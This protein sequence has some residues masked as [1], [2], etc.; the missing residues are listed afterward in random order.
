VTAFA[1]L[2][3]MQKKTVLTLF[4]IVVVGLLFRLIAY[5]FIKI[6]WIIFDEFIY[7]DTARQIVRGEFISQLLRD[8]QRYPFG[9]PLIIASFFG[10]IK[11]PYLQYRLI[12]LFVM[13]LSSVVPVLA[14]KL[15]KNKWVS[16]LTAFY[17]P[18]FVYS[19]SIM[20]ETFY[21]FLLLLLMIILK[22]VVKKDLK[23][24]Y[25]IILSGAVVGLLLYFSRQ[26]RSFGIV[27]LPSMIG[28]AAIAFLV[29]LRARK[30]DNRNLTKFIVFCGSIFV[31]YFVCQVVVA[32]LIMPKGGFY[33]KS[34]YLESFF[35]IINKPRLFYK[36]IFN[37]LMVS[38][39][40]LLFILPI[41]FIHRSYLYFQKKDIPQV[42]VRFCLIFLYL[43]SFGLTFLHM[44]KAAPYNK[45]YWVFSRYLD[46]TFVL[47]F[48]VS[49]NDFF[50][51]CNR[52]N[53]KIGKKVF[54]VALPVV[55]A[56][57]Y[58]LK[59]SFYYGSYKFG[60]SMAIYFLRELKEQP[61]WII[62]IGILLI[63]FVILVYKKR[64]KVVLVLFIAVYAFYAYVSIS[65]TIG[66]PRY[67]IGKYQR[68]LTD[69]KEA[70]LKIG[71][72]TPL[73][74]FKSKLT[75]ETYYLYH[76]SNPYQYLHLCS[77][78]DKIRPKRII[79]VQKSEITLPESCS[80]GYRFSYGEVIY[81]CPFGY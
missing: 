19:A 5:G 75:P 9:W 33:Q 54:F 39:V 28:A 81:Y 72:N 6:P 31:F 21:T 38:L 13:I 68:V 18:L 23:K 10:F 59:N 70:E 71:T 48:I 37:Q 65:S 79:T 7:L 40:S 36:L 3:A 66:V 63:F 76:F 57:I 11:N 29:M 42:V 46:P 58:Y 14:Y 26:V 60:N 25:Q 52:S 27:L 35:E 24:Y 56:I 53:W 62:L 50:V 16:A 41:F 8:G 22:Q 43:F 2:N 74:R 49:L 1:I 47:L 4:L 73:C 17:P 69:W 44:A 55:A 32:G 67:V 78:Y 34:V 45:E 12:L 77:T 15:T 51:Y 20:S 61:N 30:T 64:S 80:I